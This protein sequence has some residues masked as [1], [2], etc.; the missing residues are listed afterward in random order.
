MTS[1]GAGWRPTLVAIGCWSF[2]LDAVDYGVSSVSV[3]GVWLGLSAGLRPLVGSLPA[4]MLRTPLGSMVWWGTVPPW[5]PV[6]D[7][8]RFCLPGEIAWR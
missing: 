6:V 4:F 3:G 2:V 5:T 1:G 7:K 8:C